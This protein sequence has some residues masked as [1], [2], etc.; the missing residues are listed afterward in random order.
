MPVTYFDATI[1]FIRCFFTKRHLHLELLAY[2][3]IT[4]TICNQLIKLITFLIKQKLH[5][6][7]I[8]GFVLQWSALS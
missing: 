8:R 2:T 1:P 6:M 3:N 5:S 7:L 4:S